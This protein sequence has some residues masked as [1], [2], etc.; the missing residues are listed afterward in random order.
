MVARNKASVLRSLQRKQVVLPLIESLFKERIRKITGGEV[1]D[2]TYQLLE[3]KLLLK[4]VQEHIDELE[5]REDRHHSRRWHPSSISGCVTAA[6]YRRMRAPEDRSVD[7]AAAARS[8]RIFLMGHLIH[9]VVQN[10]CEQL[11]ILVEAESPIEIPKLDVEGHTDGVLKI[12]GI[13][14]IL[15]IKSCNHRYWS[16]YTKEPDYGH[17][18]QAHVYMRAKKIKRLILIYWNKATQ[19]LHEHVVPWDDE[20]WGEIRRKL[21][22]LSRAYK[23]KRP[24]KRPFDNPAGFPC[25]W[26]DYH[27]VC[28][29][30]HLRR[31]FLK[32]IRSGDHETE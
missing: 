26:C 30:E 27:D 16:K 10:L 8:S 14:Y 28:W 29:N 20:V 22:Y 2:K 19:E 21:S 15:E 25:K 23:N 7:G 1:D 3:M 31:D 9:M 24:P 11:G 12:N 4:S 6:W 17:I 5:R 13:K 18:V 32:K